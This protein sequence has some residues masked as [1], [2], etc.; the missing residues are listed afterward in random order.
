MSTPLN[1]AAHPVLREAGESPI[2]PLFLLAD[3]QLLFHREPGGERFLSRAREL[4]PSP[5]P[6]AAYL[7]ASNGDIPDYYD[8]FLAAMEGIGVRATR[9]IPASPSDEDR[10]FL[11][12]ADLILLAGGDPLRGLRAFQEGGIVERV[13][14]RYAGGAVLIGISAGAAQLGLKVWSGDGE[15]VSDGLRLVPAVIGAHDEP[16]WH[17][18]TRVITGLAGAGR[19]IGIP[20]GG[21]AIVYPDLTVEPARKALVEISVEDGVA[22]R[23]LLLPGGG[24]GGRAAE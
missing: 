14:T 24:G 11:D 9:H 13:L 7:G 3:S 6:R 22:R 10:A 21:G 16:D 18:L 15:S 17:A 5:A 23:A 20:A 19:G 4:L 8:I 2:R 1:G 12:E